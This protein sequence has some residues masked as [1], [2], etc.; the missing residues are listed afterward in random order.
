M[1]L[2][3]NGVTALRDNTVTPHATYRFNTNT[4]SVGTQTEMVSRAG[5]GR[6]L[7]F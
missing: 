6:G 2:R 5:S 7:P 1:D 4:R 3:G